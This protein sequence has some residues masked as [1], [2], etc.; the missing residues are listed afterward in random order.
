[1][2]RPCRDMDFD[3]ILAVINDGAS[4]YK[5]VI[6]ADRWHEPYMSAAELKR[7]MDD[8]VRFWCCEEE[9][10]LIACMGVQDRG[11]VMLIRHAYVRTTR[12]RQGWGGRLLRHLESGIDRPILIGTWAAATW[13]V[14]CYRKAGYALVPADAKTRLLKRFWDI[15]SRQVE[16]SVVLAKGRW[17]DV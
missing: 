1:M 3:E 16:T 13:A 14:D 12:R 17:V 9:G 4:A 7:E 10:R 15:P 2:I 6:P 11:A 8:G 5:G